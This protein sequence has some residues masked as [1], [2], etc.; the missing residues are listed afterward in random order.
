M[1]NPNFIEMDIRENISYEVFM[2]EYAVPGKPVLLKGMTK[3]WNAT[4]LWDE[5]YFYDKFGHLK[6]TV[7]NIQDVEKQMLLSE[8]LDYMFITTERL[9]YYLR[10]VIIDNDFQVLATHY[11]TPS[12]FRCLTK[13]LPSHLRPVWRWLF[14]GARNTNSNLHVDI[15]GTHAWNAVI[16]GKKKW[17]FYPPKDSPKILCSPKKKEPSIMADIKCASKPTICIQEEGDIVFTP[18]NWVHSVINLEPCIA[19]TENYID[20]SNIKEVNESLVK[21]KMF[22]QINFFR[23]FIPELTS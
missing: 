14:F 21:G 2:R 6:V 18:S 23:Q 13:R 7:R 10:D 1:I 15:L 8:Y 5:S 9:P 22:E 19:I 4:N 17:H 12:F 16:R 20:L 3:D 11:T